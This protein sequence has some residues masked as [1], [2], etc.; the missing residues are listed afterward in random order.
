MVE[1]L[2]ANINEQVITCSVTGNKLVWSL[3]INGAK[4]KTIQFTDK[5]DIGEEDTS[6]DGVVAE[7]TADD[8]TTLS[9]TLTF[10]PVNG[11]DGATVTCQNRKKSPQHSSM[12]VVDIAGNNIGNK[13]LNTCS[14]VS[15]AVTYEID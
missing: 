12:C 7:F 2:C 10:V 13:L 9:S 1:D 5:D 11:I 15:N 3:E 6:I 8:G 14:G 4:T